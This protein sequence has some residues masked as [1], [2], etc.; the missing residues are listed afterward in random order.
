MAVLVGL[1]GG[2]RVEKETGPGSG[3]LHLSGAKKSLLEIARQRLVLGATVL[4]VAF[5]GL[6]LRLT[7]VV[8][9]GEALPRQMVPPLGEAPAALGR[10]NI[11]DRN[12]ILLATSVPAQSLY[13]NPQHVRDPAGLANKLVLLLERGDQRALQTKLGSEGSFVWLKHHLTPW[14]HTQVNALGGP[15]LHFSVEHRRVYTHGPL[16][17]HV[18]GY[19]KMEHKGLAG[20][21]NTFDKDLRQNPHQPLTLSIDVR[22]QHVMREELNR[23]LLDHRA[24]GAAG[25]ILDVKT[26]GLRAMVSLPDFDPNNEID[27]KKHAQATFNRASLGLYEMGSTFKAFTLAMALDSGMVTLQDQF[28]ATKPLRIGN[29]AIRDF[30]AQSRWLS[31]PEIFIHSSNIGAARIAL[32]IGGERQK[33]FLGRMGLLEKMS[34]DLPEI[35]KP[36]YPEIWREINTATISYGHGISVSPIHLA[37]GVAA[38]VNGG[39]WSPPTLIRR[40]EGLVK[41]RRV[42]TEATS[43]SMQQLFRLVVTHGTGGRAEVEGYLVGGKTGTANKVNVGKKGYDSSRV[44]SSFVGVFPMSEPKYLILVLFD[45]PKGK[46]SAVAQNT[47]GWV[48]APVVGNVIRRIGPMTGIA[49]MLDPVL[50]ASAPGI[51]VKLD[52]DEIRLAAH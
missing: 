16:V 8:L 28:D 51:V 22:F 25:I 11:L 19:A 24:I 36:G 37:A 29:A 4:T 50:D 13:A 7:E 1:M 45:E 31:V 14:E 33:E 15:G 38:L 48:A 12:G 49:P 2:V 30:H 9:L 52:G 39:V 32:A 44:I 23:G 41:G 21:E 40:K 17:A 34:F 46:N 43:R 42:I 35:S 18:L 20:I 6:S 10:A 26:G 27:P 5:L 3:S 47:G